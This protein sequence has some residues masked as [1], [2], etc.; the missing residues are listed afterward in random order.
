MN[1]IELKS[2]KGDAKAIKVYNLISVKQSSEAILDRSITYYW[3][4]VNQKVQT[5]IAPVSRH[6]AQIVFIDDAYYMF[7]G[8]SYDVH[9]DM[10][11]LTKNYNW[12]KV[13]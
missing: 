3:Q 4:V 2:V 10:Y 7:G 9:N 13:K 1:S 6:S 8:R 12:I 11:K 5:K